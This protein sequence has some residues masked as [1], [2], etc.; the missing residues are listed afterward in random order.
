MD[1]HNLPTE[2]SYNLKCTLLGSIFNMD[3]FIHINIGSHR[4]W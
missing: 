1:D 4:A 2:I 3:S